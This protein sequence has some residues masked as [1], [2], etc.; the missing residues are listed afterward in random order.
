MNRHF[1]IDT[2][3]IALI[4]LLLI[5]GCTAKH[6]FDI[7]QTGLLCFYKHSSATNEIPM[8]KDEYIYLIL[9]GEYVK[10]YSE[11][12]AEGGELKLSWAGELSGTYKNGEIVVIEETTIEGIK[13]KIQHVYQYTDNTL[14]E[15]VGNRSEDVDG[16]QYLMEGGTYN[17]PF[18][19]IRCQ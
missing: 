17:K 8:H 11:S 10:G 13:Q 16:I 6:K 7:H 9:D 14:T 4:S 2:E 19:S 5:S 12:K 15:Y 1:G 18:E 3:I